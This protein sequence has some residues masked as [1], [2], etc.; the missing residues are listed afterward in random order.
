MLTRTTILKISSKNSCNPEFSILLLESSRGGNSHQSE[1]NLKLRPLKQISP[2]PARVFSPAKIVP[3]HNITVLGSTGS[4]GASTLDVVRQNRHRFQIYALA[5]GRNLDVLASQILEFTPKRVTVPDPDRL[6]QLL[7]GR[8]IP[9]PDLSQDLNSIATDPAVHTVMSSIVGIAGLDATYRA[10]RAGKRIGL[11]NKETLV[12]AGALFM[13]AVRESGSELIPVDSEHNGAHQCLRAGRRSEVARLMLT[14]SG[15]PFRNL[16]AERFASVTPRQAL[17]HPTWRMGNRITIDSATLMNKGFE[18]IEACWLF[19]FA[20]SEVDVVVH[21]QSSVHAMVE[22]NDGSIVAQISA[23]DMR[24]PIQY[25]LTWPERA[26][27][28]VPK[29]DWTQPRTWDFARPISIAS[30]PSVL[31]TGPS[32]RA[33]RRVAPSMQPMKS[34]LRHFSKSESHF[35][36][37]RLLLKRLS[38]ACRYGGRNPLRMFWRLI[39]NPAKLPG[40]SSQNSLFL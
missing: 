2:A 16:P 6:A 28:P 5:A 34:P 39:G 37:L 23:T 31:P 30:P 20:S 29:M 10:A 26:S 4:I 27:T 15:G 33:V 38:P 40:R 24:M 32:K 1:T 12:S 22:Y 7:A 3:L 19:G 11:A 36:Q 21:P 9:I 8:G 25:A 35:P 14:A 18:V 13:Q 17:R